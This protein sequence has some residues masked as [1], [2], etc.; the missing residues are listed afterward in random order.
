MNF[1]NDEIDKLE[2]Q[3]NIKRF[4]L[5]FYFGFIFRKFFSFVNVLNGRT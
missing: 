3:I 5:D 4:Y 2:S 1:V